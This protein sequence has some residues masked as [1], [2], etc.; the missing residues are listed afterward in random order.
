MPPQEVARNLGVSAPT[1]YRWLPA[2][3]GARCR[4]IDVRPRYSFDKTRSQYI[5][6]GNGL[7]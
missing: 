5:T 7:A 4:E 3:G 6:P 2:G 1:R